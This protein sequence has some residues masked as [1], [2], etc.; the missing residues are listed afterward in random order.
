MWFSLNL[1]IF[2]SK[3]TPCRSGQCLKVNFC[4]LFWQY[5]WFLAEYETVNYHPHSGMNWKL[6]C[7]PKHI[8]ISRLV[9][10]SKLY[11]WVNTNFIDSSPSSPFLLSNWECQSAE[12]DSVC[13]WRQQPAVTMRLWRARNSISWHYSSH[14][15]RP[16]C[17]LVKRMIFTAI[18]RKLAKL[19]QFAA[20]P[21]RELVNK[22]SPQY[23]YGSFVTCAKNY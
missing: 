17:Q 21:N 13:Y 7:L 11:E 14:V 3:V 4:Q 6:N 8:F 5:F 9:T 1:P 22:K 19:Q 10:V 15:G 18:K 20:L 16:C 23:K 12:D 2:V